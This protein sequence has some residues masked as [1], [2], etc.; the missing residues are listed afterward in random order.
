[1]L[2]IRSRDL[3]DAVVLPEVVDLVPQPLGMDRGRMQLVCDE[4]LSQLG[5][6]SLGIART[7]V[8]V[9]TSTDSEVLV[10]EDSLAED[11]RPAALALLERHSIVDVTVDQELSRSVKLS[12]SILEPLLVGEVSKADLLQTQGLRIGVADCPRLV[13]VPNVLAKLA[14]HVDSVVRRGF[15]IV[16]DRPES[17]K[18]LGWGPAG[19]IPSLG[20]VQHEPVDP[21]TLPGGVMRRDVSVLNLHL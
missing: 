21:G 6:V 19:G 2:L 1:M 14:M 13:A 8:G 10:L 15:L 5:N 18:I 11:R 3:S 20:G 17:D 7:A 16:E 4:V 12:V 9:T